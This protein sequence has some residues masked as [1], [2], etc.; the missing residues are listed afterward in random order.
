[1]TEPHTTI[2]VPYS[3]S[4]VEAVETLYSYVTAQP[5]ASHY[6]FDMSRVD[7]VKPHGVIALVL[8]ARML[9]K[10]SGQPVALTS[11]HPQVLQYLERIDLFE[12]GHEWLLPPP[13]LSERWFRSAATPNLLELTLITGPNDVSVAMARASHIF[14]RWLSVSDLNNLLAVL[15]EV[16]ANIYQHS[17]DPAG[18]VVI[19][20]YALVDEVAIC[21][22]VGDLGCGIRGSLQARHGVLGEGS[23]F[24][25]REAM[26]GRTSRASGRGG[27][28]LRFVE[29]RARD[30]GGSFWLRTEN[31]ALH[32][33][34][35][36]ARTESSDLAGVPGTQLVVEL[37]APL[38]P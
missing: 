36:L 20:K 7:F 33:R 4:S 34:G 10:R 28:G 19:Q 12:I 35:M 15:S 31:A 21:L 24:Y 22:A 1:M 9:A 8:A 11:L 17:G 23:L 6:A 5:L 38:H 27:L 18:C 30:T 25:L 29:R 14:Q 32:S 2:T 13:K 26:N 16:C 3:L 37:H